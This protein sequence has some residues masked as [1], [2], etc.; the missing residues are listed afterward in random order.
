MRGGYGIVR[1]CPETSGA[2]RCMLPGATDAE[3]V[4]GLAQSLRLEPSPP[5]YAFGTHRAVSPAETLRRIRPLLRPAGITR[6]ADVTGL[7]WIGVPV[8]QAIRPRSRLLAV[9][10]GKGLTRAQAQVSALM[11]SLEG[12]HAEDV[13]LPTVR[14]TVGAMRRLLPYDPA[15]L[16]LAHA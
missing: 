4:A 15:A 10:Q 5:G 1:A 2:E 13:T 8:Y 3:A 6:L 12:F 11:E 14:D 16:P 7:D 9:S